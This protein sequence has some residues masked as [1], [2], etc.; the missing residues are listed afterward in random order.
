MKNR[1]RGDE[2]KTNFATMKKLTS[3]RWKNRLRGD[4]KIDFAVM[5]NQL[6][7]DEKIDFAAMKKS[8]SRRSKNRLRGDEKI[9]CAAMKKPAVAESSYRTLEHH[10][11]GEQ[12][13][14][15]CLLENYLRNSPKL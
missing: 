13:R 15:L 5:K 3:R 1:L 7:G 4:E 14:K 8:N 12:K 11:R 6:R 9:E 2:K 10:L